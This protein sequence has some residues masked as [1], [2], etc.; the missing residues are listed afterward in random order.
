M[1]IEVGVLQQSQREGLHD[2]GHVGELDAPLKELVLE[3]G[4][5]ADQLTHV[6][7][8]RVAKLGDTA[9]RVCVCVCGGGGG[10]GG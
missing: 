7:L 10:G 8:V 5:Q 6:H 1:S 2:D 9:W 4:S 3:R